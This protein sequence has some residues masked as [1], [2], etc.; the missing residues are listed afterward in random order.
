MI[1]I[2]YLATIRYYDFN[3]KIFKLKIREQ[4]DVKKLY[5]CIHYMAIHL[6]LE[7]RGDNSFLL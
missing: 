5:E 2:L 1:I 3:K 7:K 4:C 6:Q